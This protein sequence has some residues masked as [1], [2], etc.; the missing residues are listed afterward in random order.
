VKRHLEAYAGAGNVTLTDLT[1]RLCKIDIQGPMSARILTCRLQA[2]GT[3]L[4]DPRY[5]KFRG[6]FDEKPLAA[7]TVRLT[8]GTPILLAR[9]GYTEEFGFEISSFWTP[10]AT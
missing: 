3:I 5:F 4:K 1:D 8:D 10:P 9:T 6:H 2:P 7:G